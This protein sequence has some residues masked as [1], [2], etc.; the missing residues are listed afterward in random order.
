MTAPTPEPTLSVDECAKVDHPLTV[1][2]LGGLTCPCGS[3]FEFQY[4]AT[5]WWLPRPEL[6]EAHTGGAVTAPMPEPPKARK[7]II[8]STSEGGPG[9]FQILVGR[10]QFS[11]PPETDSRMPQFDEATVLAFFARERG[12]AWVDEHR[13]EVLSRAREIGL[14]PLKH[15]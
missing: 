15:D 13:E 1:D 10:P 7:R 2:C 9:A 8:D 6:P 4:H 3:S 5:A 11:V 14:V 12:Q